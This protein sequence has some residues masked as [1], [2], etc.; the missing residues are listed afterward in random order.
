MTIDLVS[1]VGVTG[2]MC[3]ARLG[4]ETKK[5]YE[6]LTSIKS[7][8]SIPLFFLLWNISSLPP[9]HSIL[10]TFLYSFLPSHFYPFLSFFLPSSHSSFL[11]SFLPIFPRVVSIS[12]LP[13][14]LPFFL[15]SPSPLG[16]IQVCDRAGVSVC[17]FGQVSSAW[18]AVVMVTWRACKQL[19]NDK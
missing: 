9:S 13:S 18:G 2:L 3:C 11:L 8:S 7:T 12:S 16:H 15:P 6:P 10:P 19:H 4:N 14:L 5:R 17:G 1:W